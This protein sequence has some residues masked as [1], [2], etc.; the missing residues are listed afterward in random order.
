MSESNTISITAPFAG[1]ARAR[2]AP[3]LALLA[4]LLAELLYLT[5]T[6]DTQPL[7]RI[8]SAWT[9]F[10]GWSPQYLRLAISIAVLTVLFGG[11]RF[12]AA[13]TTLHPAATPA[14]R[15]PYLTLHGIALVAFV[16]V[17]AT[18]FAAGRTVAA[19]PA[20]WTI[21]WCAAGAVTIGAWGLAVFPARHWREVIREQRMII[22]CGIAAGT[23]VWGSGFITEA[24]WKPLGRY[25]FSVVAAV[26]RM[27]YPD[28]VTVPER[29]LVGT[30]SFRVHIAPSCS[31]YEGVGLILAFLGIYLYLFRKDLRF[32][33]ALIL[34]PI[35]AL[36]IWVLNA[37]RIVALVV[38]GTSGWRD[39]ALGGFHS[40]AGWLV[41]NAVGLAFVAVINRH[42]YFAHNPRPVPVVAGSAAS[43]STTAFLGPFVAMLAAAMVTG[44]FSAGLDW[45]YPLRIVA[46][47]AVMW[48]CW[49]AYSNLKWSCSFGAFAIGIAT[50]VVWMAMLPADLTQKEGW[51]AALRAMPSSW[52]GAW[53]AVRL[54]GY[55]LVAP[56]AE[57]LAF[58]G[59]ATRRLIREDID[60]VPVGAFSWMSFLLSS[61]VFGLFHGRLWLSGTVAGMAFA[62]AMYRRRSFGDAVL[63]HATTNGLIACYVFATG[64]WSVWS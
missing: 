20:L 31:G 7:L 40:Q 12:L 46:A 24:F 45:L 41:F 48:S 63:A 51:P 14:P 9:V 19:H 3:Q 16:S 32:P 21:G 53:L 57:E 50:F 47:A 10:L 6:L 55:V 37:A 62:Y 5:V 25:T 39:I 38:I 2:F 43:S 59:Y 17:S 8:P 15:L 34:L 42:G 52:A 49:R 29:L 44:S 26:L 35:G 23:A 18:L 60:T 58:R 4:L 30:P 36:A 56:V 61:L 54:I 1:T 22:A 27:V 11:R 64:R 33:A 28:T 13:V